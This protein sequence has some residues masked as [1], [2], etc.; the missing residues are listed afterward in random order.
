MLPSSSPS[1]EA[2]LINNKLSSILSRTKSSEFINYNGSMGSNVC[3][4]ASSFTFSNIG[5]A[6]PSHNT[7]YV[8]IFDFYYQQI[9]ASGKEIIPVDGMWFIVITNEFIGS[10]WYDQ[11][12]QRKVVVFTDSINDEFCIITKQDWCV[13][14][15]KST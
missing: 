6:L 8:L 5:F 13:I 7:F 15:R 12:R 4:V 11:T 14:Y 1:E 2:S 10:T 9:L 3:L